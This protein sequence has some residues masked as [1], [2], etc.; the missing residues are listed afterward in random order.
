MSIGS[1]PASGLTAQTLS[2]LY[3]GTK[4]AAQSG[5]IGSFDS[6][7][8][9]AAE[10]QSH[11]KISDITEVS[12]TASKFTQLV[13]AS[14]DGILAPQQQQELINNLRESGKSTSGSL[15]DGSF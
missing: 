7:L 9:S 13:D 14:S 15:F 4:G 11:P 10:T 1:I 6:A 12:Q 5:G 2:G 8:K 3:S